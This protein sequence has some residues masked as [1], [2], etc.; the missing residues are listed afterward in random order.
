MGDG[1]NDVTS[2]KL[3]ADDSPG[4]GMAVRSSSRP[5]HPI[6]RY[7]AE[8]MDASGRDKKVCRTSPR[9]IGKALSAKSVIDEEEDADDRTVEK[10]LKKRVDGGGRV[11]Y[12][13]KW[14]GLHSR[15]NSWK[16]RD[17]LKNLHV[18]KQYEKEQSKHG[19]LGEEEEHEEEGEDKSGEEEE[20]GEDESGVEEEEGEDESD[21]EGEE[22]KDD[23]LEEEE[24]QRKEKGEDEKG[25]EDDE[26][27]VVERILAKRMNKNGEAEC[28]VKWQGYN[29]EMN[30]WEP[31]DGIKHL[32]V[33]KRCESAAAAAAAAAGTEKASGNQNSANASPPPVPL[34]RSLL[35]SLTWSIDL[36]EWRRFIN[37]NTKAL[38]KLC[39]DSMG[40]DMETLIRHIVSDKDPQQHQPYAFK[41]LQKQLELGFPIK[42]FESQPSLTLTGIDILQFV[43][44]I[45]A[46][47]LFERRRF[48]NGRTKALCKLCGDS[49]WID[50]ETL[51][52]HIA[53]NEDLEH[54]Q[55]AVK[56]VQ[57]QLDS[58][59]TQPQGQS[60]S[61]RTMQIFLRLLT[62]RTITLEVQAGH[63]VADVKEMIEA[64]EGIPQFDQRLI[65]AGKQLEE[66]RTL[67][68]CNVQKAS[69]VQLLLCCR[70]G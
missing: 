1:F 65:F 55:Y 11:E 17:V 38:C 31:S 68:D 63:T 10:V 25:E 59:I 44:A 46:I 56:L 37:G 14:E 30:S 43:R 58:A 64:K 36:F 22:K 23:N 48:I 29:D 52:R 4:G 24:E 47:D 40:V 8:V 3:H 19:N 7:V 61:V 20:E 67:A 53:T 18:V 35:L 62:G 27:F 69:T 28:L 70:G 45:W 39:G 66:K 60:A 34:K 33:F 42:S 50:L 2:Q 9:H 26:G 54:L 51:I 32:D 16:P 6:K 49:L 57:K 12:F 21:E 41:L 15:W 5:R 13:V